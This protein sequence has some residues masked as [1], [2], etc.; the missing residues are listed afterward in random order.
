M[1]RERKRMH[2]SKKAGFDCRS[3]KRLAMKIVLPSHGTIQVASYSM[4]EKS[5]FHTWIA[6]QTRLIETES[7][8]AVGQDHRVVH[9]L[10]IVEVP[11]G[12]EGPL[13]RLSRACD[14][15]VNRLQ[16][17]RRF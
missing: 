7:R 5:V 16:E 2:P 10:A 14:L 13:Q 11:N 9:C 12:G 15:A 6:R 17:H 1:D 4:H 3:D 8:R